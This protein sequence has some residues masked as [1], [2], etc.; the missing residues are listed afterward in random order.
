MFKL[1]ERRFLRTLR[2]L[3]THYQY[4]IFCQYIIFYLSPSWLPCCCTGTIPP[5][6]NVLLAKLTSLSNH[7]TP[8]HLFLF[9]LT[10]A[11]VNNTALV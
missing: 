3:F 10:H 6:L 11:I 7:R 9:S 4:I 2:R 8:T 5:K 1:L